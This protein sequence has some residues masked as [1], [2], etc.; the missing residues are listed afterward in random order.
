MEVAGL[1]VSEICPARAVICPALTARTEAALASGADERGAACAATDGCACDTARPLPAAV[2][3]PRCIAAWS[4]CLPAEWRSAPAGLPP[5]APRAACRVLPAGLWLSQPVGL[6]PPPASRMQPPTF[7]AS[8][9]AGRQAPG[10]FAPLFMQARPGGG[11]GMAARLSVPPPPLPLHLPSMLGT[12]TQFPLDLVQLAC[13]SACN[14]QEGTTGC[15]IQKEACVAHGR[16]R[17]RRRKAAGWEGQQEQRG[18]ATEGGSASCWRE[19]SGG[20]VAGRQEGPTQGRTGKC[21]EEGKVDK[22]GCVSKRFAWCAN[23]LGRRRQGASCRCGGT[24]DEV[25]KAA[26]TPRQWS[27]E[28]RSAPGEGRGHRACHLSGGGRAHGVTSGH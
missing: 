3:Q 6:R 23:E 25:A 16:R 1:Q 27:P 24:T 22:S 19:Q 15:A 4:R 7:A 18:S 17:E 2:T 9:A 8:D 26:V 10:I 28:G 11:A 21:I 20:S 13:M 5:E 12:P 14:M